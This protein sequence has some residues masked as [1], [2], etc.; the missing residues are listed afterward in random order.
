MTFTFLLAL[1]LCITKLLP[2][3]LI[4]SIVVGVFGKSFRLA[5]CFLGISVLFSSM[6]G[7]V[8]MMSVVR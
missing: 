2:M 8:T 5:A 7:T 6:L 1:Y 4:P 3:L